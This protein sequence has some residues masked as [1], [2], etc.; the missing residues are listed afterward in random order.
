MMS[1]DDVAGIPDKEMSSICINLPVP[2]LV[3]AL[4]GA[5]AEVVEKFL[6]HVRPD[7]A[8]MTR[9]MVRKQ[10]VLPAADVEAARAKIAGIIDKTRAK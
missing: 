7:M 6:T 3:K 2:T 8:Q 5:R 1:F 10:G 4:C 9:D